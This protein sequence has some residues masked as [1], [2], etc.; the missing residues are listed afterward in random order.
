MRNSLGT[1]ERLSKSLVTILGLVTIMILFPVLGAHGILD[2]ATDYTSF[3][4]VNCVC[5]HSVF[6]SRCNKFRNK[7]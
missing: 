3:V 1:S 7:Y 5:G 4:L 6:G 2:T